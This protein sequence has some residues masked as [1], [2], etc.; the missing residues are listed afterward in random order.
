MTAS[1]PRERYLRFRRETGRPPALVRQIV[2]VRGLGMAVFSTPP[3]RG[4]AP[5]LCIN[6]G[7]LFDHRSL[8]PTLAPLAARR[9]LVLYDQRGRGESEAPP[10]PR[11][12]TIEED[13]ADI[14]ALR[15][16]LGVRQ[17][18]VLGHSFGGAIA[19]LG[20]AEDVAGTRRLVLVDPVGVTSDWVQPLRGAV[21]ARLDG[22][23][24]ETV[25]RMEDTVL[26]DPDPEVQLEYAMAVHRAWFADP[27][28]AEL[29]PAVR[30][31]SA[32][33]AAVSARLRTTPY[34]WRSRVRALSAPSLVL[35]G[36]QDPLPLATARLVAETLPSSRLTVL[37]GAGHMPF[38]EAPEQF[39]RL[40]DEFLSALRPPASS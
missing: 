17:W 4:A 19:M 18:D 31:L 26:A 14:G 22:Q 36:E 37:P 27:S 5:L 16:A 3:V 39:F 9:Q 35:H 24:R 2:R 8:W 32:A 29:L 28:L 10:A 34:D 6:G 12:A 23:A 38:W 13:A 15:R 11:Q 40:V 7:L 25:R 30:A 20:C 21:L 33:G 1:T